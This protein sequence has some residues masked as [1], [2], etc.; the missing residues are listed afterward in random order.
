M[1]TKSKTRA[2]SFR[3]GGSFGTF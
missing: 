2:G 1:K 3:A